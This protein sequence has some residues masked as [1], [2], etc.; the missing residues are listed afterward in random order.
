MTQQA[1]NTQGNTA[2]LLDYAKALPQYILPHHLLSAGMHWLA[3]RETPWLKNQII[4]FI[5]KKFDVDMSVAVE[6]NPFAYRSFN[7]FFTRELKPDARPICAP[8]NQLASPVDGAVSQVGLIGEDV[9]PGSLPN[10]DIFQAKGHYYS[11]EDLLG[12]DRDRAQAFV[13]GHF[14]TIY[15]SPR[16]YHRIHCPFAG[17][18]RE[19]IHIPG[20]QFSVS[21]ATARA[22]PNLFARNERVACIFDTEIGPM[23]VIMVGAIFVSSIETVWAGEVTPPSSR[24]VRTW[25]YDDNEHSFAKGDEIGRFNMGSTVILLFGPQMIEWAQHMRAEQKVQMGENLAEVNLP[26]QDAATP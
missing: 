20:R 11:L 18:L 16:D 21:P 1:N 10:K 24:E 7:H 8:E 15:L 17:T 26:V 5:H 13:G 14:S 9:Q 3:R 2:S 19:M 6:E 22:V 12:G 23:A 4:R 25:T